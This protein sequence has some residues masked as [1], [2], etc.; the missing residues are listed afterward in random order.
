MK[1]IIEE[2]PEIIEEVTR[3]IPVTTMSEHLLMIIVI[4]LFLMYI[5]GK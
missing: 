5:R 3:E 4:I 2:L 1:E